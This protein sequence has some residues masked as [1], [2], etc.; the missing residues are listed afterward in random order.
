[1]GRACETAELPKQ[2]GDYPVLGVLGEGGQ[3][4]VYRAWHPRLQAEIA[5]K[6]MHSSG[7]QAESALVHEALLISSARNAAFPRPLDLKR[8]DNETFLFLELIHGEPLSTGGSQLTLP[9]ILSAMRELVAAI[10]ELHAA[11][12]LHLDLSPSNIL[13]DERGAVRLIDFGLARR[14]DD[15]APEVAGTRGFV[16][17]EIIEQGG[18]VDHRADVYSAGAVLYYLLCGQPPGQG[19]AC[20]RG[21]KPQFE[22]LPL[23]SRLLVLCG[24]A[25]EPQAAQRW[26]TAEEFL[27]ALDDIDLRKPRSRRGII[28]ATLASAVV[29]GQ[30]RP[31]QRVAQA[32]VL[33]VRP[34]G[35]RRLR[36]SPRLT[37]G[38]RVAFVLEVNSPSAGLFLQTPSGRAIRLEPF[39]GNGNGPFRFPSAGGATL[40]DE[41]GT[42]V[43]LF[44]PMLE[45]STTGRLLFR[46][47]LL[48]PPPRLPGGEFLHV[49]RGVLSGLTRERGRNVTVQ[50][51]LD[52]IERCGR[53]FPGLVAIA[54][55]VE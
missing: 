40:R 11:G 8:I 48:P 6:R 41:I 2:I 16:P 20:S 26:Q 45:S 24:K 53:E 42:Y 9:M 4:I 49:G 23:A 21:L 54:F 25:L 12:L 7:S 36:D 10:A 34:E 28:A 50:L 52:A 38:D 55:P 35:E 33:V 19:E 46:I 27:R 17:P 14:L 30:D 39:S 47:S 22:R 3:A 18:S 15:A 13:I 37:L 5:I 31:L 43:V 29:L 1:M 32:D 44:L 51:W